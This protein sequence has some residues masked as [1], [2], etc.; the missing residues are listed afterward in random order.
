VFI[1]QRMP[2]GLEASSVGGMEL[3][4]A[5]YHACNFPIQGLRLVT[6]A[7]RIQ[8][9]RDIL[10]SKKS[11]LQVGRELGLGH[12]SVVKLVKH[13]CSAFFDDEAMTLKEMRALFVQS[14]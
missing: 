13:F 3:T 2:Q 9:L 1:L 5:A 12:N 8:G 4:R 6:D 11:K 7:E 14:T 10:L